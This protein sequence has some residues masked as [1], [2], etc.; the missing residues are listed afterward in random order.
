MQDTKLFETILGIQAPWR[1]SRVVLD[2]SAERIDLWAEH[3]SDTR[4]PCPECQHELPCRDHVDDRV[5]RHLDTCQYQ[6]F[7][8]ARVPRVCCPTHGVRQVRNSASPWLTFPVPSVISVRLTLPR[9]PR[10]TRRAATIA[11]T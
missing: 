10:T 11:H 8:H 2:T 4:W 7:L 6:T 9:T 5:W 1:I 3:A